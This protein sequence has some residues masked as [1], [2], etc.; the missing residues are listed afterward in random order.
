MFLYIKQLSCVKQTVHIQSLSRICPYPTIT[1]I[2]LAQASQPFS[3]G[4]ILL[5]PTWSPYFQWCLYNLDSKGHFCCCAK[6]DFTAQNPQSGKKKTM[7][8]N[9]IMICLVS[10]PLC[11]QISFLPF[12]HLALCPLRILALTFSS[13]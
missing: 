5:F 7:A 9:A 1:A 12:S 4:L 2:T 6:L 3:A 8:Y 13:A 10:T 11:L